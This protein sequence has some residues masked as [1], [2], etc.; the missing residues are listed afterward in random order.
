MEDFVIKEF[1]ERVSTEGL[2]DFWTN[3][4]QRKMQEEPVKQIKV[5]DGEK[6]DFLPWST[7]FSTTNAAGNKKFLVHPPKPM[8][9]VYNK[10]ANLSKRES[11]YAVLDHVVRKT[12]MGHYTEI[13]LDRYVSYM[14][15]IIN[16]NPKKYGRT[17]AEEYVQGKMA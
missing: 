13:P 3:L 4:G 17:T 11:S 16:N 15:R 2:Q 8:E 9:L 7:D 5:V 6:I 10:D 1:N 12:A 14:R